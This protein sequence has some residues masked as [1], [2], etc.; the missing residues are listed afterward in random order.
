MPT[1]RGRL[2]TR[3]LAGIGLGLALVLG[4][5]PDADAQRSRWSYPLKDSREVRDSFQ[6]VVAPSASSTVQILCKGSPCSLG[7]VIGEEGWV[8]TKASELQGDLTC[9]LPGGED[10]AIQSMFVEDSYDLALLQVDARELTPVQWSEEEV[11]AGDVLVT[12]GSGGEPLALGVVGV[13]TRRIP[14]RGALLGVMLGNSD[15]GP[16]ITRVVPDSAA[17]DAGLRTNDRIL[18]IDGRSFGE[19]RDIVAYVSSKRAGTVVDMR[20][21]R[22]GRTMR[23]RPKLGS[24][25]PDDEGSL[26]G[27]TSLIRSG[28]PLAFQH[29][30]LLTPRECGGPV[31]GLDG[32]AVGVNI[33]RAGRT[34]TYAVPAKAVREVVRRLQR[35]VEA[36]TR[37]SF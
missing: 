26:A 15:A 4:G 10:V 16:L 20:V 12:P 11:L 13:E 22:R 24:Q 3:S 17:D 34:E 7:T 25:D 21:D 18:E 37:K 8:L 1:L 27:P 33:A 36:G 28:F 6:A 5:T 35:R 23:F 14:Q 30:S 29:D 19:N 32:R 31:L 2:T 9:R